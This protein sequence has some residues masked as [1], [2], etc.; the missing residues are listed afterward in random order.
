M[1]RAEVD[2]GRPVGRRPL[3]L[4]G[5]FVGH[6]Q[7]LHVQHMRG[8]EDVSGPHTLRLRCGGCVPVGY[9]HAHALC[10]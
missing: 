1:K 4:W 5:Q 3:C 10:A 9:L 8:G 7:P 6:T 2:A